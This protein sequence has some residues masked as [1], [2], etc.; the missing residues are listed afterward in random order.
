LTWKCNDRIPT[1]EEAAEI[2]VGIGSQIKLG[3]T[4]I[5]PDFSQIKPGESQIK[6][7]FSQINNEFT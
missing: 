7:E 4:Q 2:I 5:N 3:F 1:F 6:L